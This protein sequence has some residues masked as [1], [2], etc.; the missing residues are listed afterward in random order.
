MVGSKN[1][2]LDIA[3]VGVFA[4]ILFAQEELL[5]ILPNI[6]LTVFLL[7]LYSK[8]LGCI[9]TLLIALLHVILD[10]FV[11]G[12]FSVFYTPFMFFG[13]ALIPILLNTVFKKVEQPFPL[14][15]CGVLFAF[16]YSWMY[17]IPTVTILH[18]NPIHYLMA[19]IVFEIILA[20]SS[21]LS[22]LWLYNPCAKVFD[23]YLNK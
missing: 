12:S 13:W 10:N 3:L 23:L 2:V 8:K 22:I 14:A 18:M 16:L 19:D 21:F 17:V 1:K 9:K 15:L 7:V 20:C 11:L 6:Q 5:T 4:A